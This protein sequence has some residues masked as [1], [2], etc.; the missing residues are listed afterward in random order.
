MTDPLFPTLDFVLMGVTGMLP[1]FINIKLCCIKITFVQSY[2]I[3]YKLTF[4]L[5][6]YTSCKY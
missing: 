6:Y 1:K 5:N 3:H 2:Q 4:K